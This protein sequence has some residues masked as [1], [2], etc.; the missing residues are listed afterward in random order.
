MP[1]RPLEAAVQT[2]RRIS[3]NPVDRKA[4]EEL[5]KVSSGPPPHGPAP[6]HPPGPGPRHFAAGCTDCLKLAHQHMGTFHLQMSHV[7]ATPVQAGPLGVLSSRYLLVTSQWSPGFRALSFIPHWSR[8]PH[9]APIVVHP[10]R[11]WADRV[12]FRLPPAWWAPYPCPY[13]HRL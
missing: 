11:C 10:Q 12:A 13:R 4:E 1:V 9:G 2:W 3:T 8:K 7:Q 6:V 5:R